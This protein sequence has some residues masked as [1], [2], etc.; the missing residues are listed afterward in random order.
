MTTKRKKYKAYNDFL[1]P[2]YIYK[3]MSILQKSKD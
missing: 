2:D 1:L 3:K